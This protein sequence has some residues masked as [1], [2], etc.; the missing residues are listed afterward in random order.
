LLHVLGGGPWQVPTVRLAKQM[1]YR[2]LVT[3]IYAERPAYEFCDHHEV[4]DITDRDATLAVARRHHVDGVICD[5]TDLGVPTAAYVAEQLGL[6]GIGFETALNCT[7]KDRLR[8]LLSAAGIP[9]PPFHVL[10]TRTDLAP[11]RATFRYPVVVKP[12]DSQ[13]SHGV[14]VVGHPQDLDQAFE[15]AKTASREGIVLIEG[16]VTGVEI[17]VDGFVTGQDLRV[18]GISSKVARPENPAVATRI[19][20]PADFEAVKHEQIVDVN[21]RTIAALGLKSGI[22]HAEYMVTDTDVVPIDV[23]ARG[24]GVNIYTHVI[25]AISGV[26]V[27]RAMIEHAM[28]RPVSLQPAHTH[29]AANIEFLF[30]PPGVVERVEGIEE[31]GR[32]PGVLAVYVSAVPLRR[33]G[34]LSDKND[35]AGHIVTVG[36]TLDEAIDRSLEAK[37]RIRVVMTNGAAQ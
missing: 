27:N 4:V 5:T 34:D 16:H 14:S 25:P 21:R 33:F 6:P 32:M 29:A 26:D 20:Y 35:R 36:R 17:I 12:V 19:S 3:D 31:A 28:G 9:C 7:R 23:A 18:L 30:A 15:V 1:G 10:R 8:Q 22:F 37:D 11:L 13:S 2:V 24:G